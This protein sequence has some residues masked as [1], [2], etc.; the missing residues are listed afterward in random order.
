MKR[1]LREAFRLNRSKLNTSN[2]ILLLA[3]RRI[4]KV[5]RQEVEKDLIV[6]ACEAGIL[7]ECRMMNA[8]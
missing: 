7:K 3:R 6:L 4:L 8:E 1:L 5:S 2:D